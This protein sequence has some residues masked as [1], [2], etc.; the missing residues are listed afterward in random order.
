MTATFSVFP[1]GILLL[2]IYEHDHHN[3]V[4]FFPSLYDVMYNC[5]LFKFDLVKKVLKQIESF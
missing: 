1:L 3:T 2:F 4:R 5:K